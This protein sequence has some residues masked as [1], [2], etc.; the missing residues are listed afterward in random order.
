MGTVQLVI[1]RIK[2]I[3]YSNHKHQ[4]T[5]FMTIIKRVIIH[6]CGYRINNNN[7]WNMPYHSAA[8][9]Q[10]QQGHCWSGMDW[11]KKSAWVFLTHRPIVFLE[12][13]I[14]S[15]IMIILRIKTQ[16]RL[17]HLAIDGSVH[18]AF[19]WL[20]YGQFVSDDY[21]SGAR[22]EPQS[23]STESIGIWTAI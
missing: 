8:A 4:L 16:F 6:I 7:Y 9:C 3:M 13:P 22:A 21:R 5:F 17:A 12:T 23:Q 19:A 10:Q 15:Q 20:S 11:E 1:S 14:I 2:S 18:L